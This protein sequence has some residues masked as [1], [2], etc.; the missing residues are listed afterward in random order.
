MRHQVLRF[1][2]GPQFRKI[3][4]DD[5][6]W[7]VFTD[8]HLKVILMRRGRK[9]TIP[10]QLIV[11]AYRDLERKVPEG[12][13]I[14]IYDLHTHPSDDNIPSP[15]DIDCFIGTKWWQNYAGLE[16]GIYVVGNGVITKKGIFI[17]KMPDNEERLNELD[18]K[19]L[20]KRY[21]KDVKIH[22][23]NKLG[24]KYWKEAHP[25]AEEMGLTQEDKDVINQKAYTAS[26]KKILQ[27]EPVIKTKMIRRT[28]RFN[29]R[30]RR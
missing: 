27:E 3:L 7:K 11:D 20:D 5:H 14:R 19:R 28:H 8:L 30:R 1:P 4:E 18:K 29:M 13:T 6:E 26:F 17:V 15:Q 24:V 21:E 23:K 9:T 16:N 12:K 2:V 22:I 10:H 25:K